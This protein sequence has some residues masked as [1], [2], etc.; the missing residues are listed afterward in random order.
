MS[1]LLLLLG[2]I[3]IEPIHAFISRPA[4]LLKRQ[5]KADVAILLWETLLP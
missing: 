2:L 1:P 3:F 4:F 5:G